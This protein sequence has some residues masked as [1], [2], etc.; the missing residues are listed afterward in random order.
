VCKRVR[1]CQLLKCVGSAV[2]AFDSGVYL[3][4]VCVYVCANVCGTASS[5]NVW[6]ARCLL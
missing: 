6:A 2:F 5:S 4:G 3:F 1:D